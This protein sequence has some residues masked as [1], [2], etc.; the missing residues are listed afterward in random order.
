MTESSFIESPR[1]SHNGG[2]M[3]S[4]TI[5]NSR[6]Q[7]IARLARPCCWDSPRWLSTVASGPC[8]G[9]IEHDKSCD[10]L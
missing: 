10:Q 4:L 5:S 2:G 3:T 1:T 7:L 9:H 6:F 8:A